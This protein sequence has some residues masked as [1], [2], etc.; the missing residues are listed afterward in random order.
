MAEGGIPSEAGFY[1]WWLATD[2]KLVFSSRD[3]AA[4][5]RWQDEHLRIAWCE[6]ASPWAIERAVVHELEPPLNVDFNAG[7]SFHAAIKAARAECLAAAQ[8]A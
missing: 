6:Q 1:A 4:L 8:P 2:G 5:T 7:H 3:N